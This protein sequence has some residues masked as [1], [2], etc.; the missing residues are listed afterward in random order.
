MRAN[1]HDW[2]TD[3]YPTDDEVKELCKPGAG[4]DT[5]SWL[6]MSPSGWECCCL[7]KNPTLA[8]RHSKGEMVAM[9]DGCDKVNNFNPIGK[10]G[11]HTF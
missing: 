8:E 2:Y 11:E 9:R 3:M 6:L 5:C 10:I 4:A 1:V 7:H